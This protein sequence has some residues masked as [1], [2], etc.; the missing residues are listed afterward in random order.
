[1][2]SV[3][4]VLPLGQAHRFDVVGRVE[5]LPSRHRGRNALSPVVVAV[6]GHDHDL[7]AHLPGHVYDLGEKLDGV[8]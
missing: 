2:S 5:P 1:M 7:L 4:R 8:L 3:R 6:H